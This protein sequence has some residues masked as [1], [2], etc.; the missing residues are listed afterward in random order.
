MGKYAVCGR[1]IRLSII[2]IYSVFLFFIITVY[3]RITSLVEWVRSLLRES[4]YLLIRSDSLKLSMLVL[5][6]V[7]VMIYFEEINHEFIEL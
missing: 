5:L 4:T 7:Y 1:N 2:F 3:P 6:A